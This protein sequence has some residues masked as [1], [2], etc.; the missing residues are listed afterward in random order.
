MGLPC[1]YSSG[2]WVTHGFMT[3][4]L[5]PL[6]FTY[7]VFNTRTIDSLYLTVKKIRQSF[8]EQGILHRTQTH[9]NA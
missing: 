4:A 2:E 1:V 3:E 7:R 9:P 5:V 6:F 8:L